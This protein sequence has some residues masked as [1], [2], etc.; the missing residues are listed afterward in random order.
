MHIYGI[1]THLEAASMHIY[2]IPA[3][4]KA[5]FMHIYGI[6]AYL[7]ST[8][9]HICSIPTHSEAILGFSGSLAPG[10]HLIPIVVQ[11]ST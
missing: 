11:T 1:L 7:G 2:G 9:L 5:T 4:L 6:S 3:H 8:F 10:A